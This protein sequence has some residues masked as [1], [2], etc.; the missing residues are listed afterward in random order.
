MIKTRGYNLI[1]EDIE[2]EYLEY[3]DFDSMSFVNKVTKDVDLSSIDALTTLFEN[4]E[5]LSDYIDKVEEFHNEYN[6]SYKIIYTINKTKEEKVL[7]IV[8]NDPTLSSFSKLA[9]GKVDFSNDKNYYTFLYIIESIKKCKNGLVKRIM[10]SKKE[11]YRISD[12]NKKIIETLT[13]SKKEVS[14]KDLMDV[15]SDYKECR[16][17]YLNYKYYNIENN[18]SM[19]DS[20]KSVKQLLK[21]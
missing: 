8:W 4:Q 6:Y 5:E 17:L 14:F 10:T 12:N 20:L 1:R 19:D 7:K 11:S 13:N 9:D 21:R 16:A 18:I 3:F 2:N 15:F